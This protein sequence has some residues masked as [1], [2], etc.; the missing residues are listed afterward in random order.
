MSFKKIICALFFV[1]FSLSQMAMARDLVPENVK[2]TYS[3][4]TDAGPSLEQVIS[5]M[6]I[7]AKAEA[8]VKCNGEAVE[9]SSMQH[10]YHGPWGYTSVS[11]TFEF[12]CVDVLL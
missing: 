8:E 4:E 10:L 9:L 3:A 2:L 12:K 11:M 1:S 7:R 6:E 5:N